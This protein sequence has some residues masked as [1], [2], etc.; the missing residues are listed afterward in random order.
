MVVSNEITMKSTFNIFAETL[1]G[2]MQNKVMM[3]AHL[4]SVDAGP[5]THILCLTLSQELMI[6]EVDQQLFSKLLFLWQL[7]NSRPSSNT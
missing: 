6:M 2:N 4:D 3:G 7:Q 1:E 5:G